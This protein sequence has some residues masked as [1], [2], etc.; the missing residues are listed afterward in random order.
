MS[1]IDPPRGLL[2]RSSECEALERLLAAVRAGGS[3]VLVLRGEAGVGKTALLEHLVARAPDC[4]VAR[5]AGVESE[6]E[7]PFAGLHQLCAPL[8]D[9]LDTLPAPQRDALCTA[10]GLSAGPPPDR[11][12]VG[13]AVLGLLS[14]AAEERPLVCVVDD[15]QWQDRAS[16]LTLAFV[17]RRLAADSV[18]LVFAVREPSEGRDLAGLPEL[19]VHGLADEAAR[20]LLDSVIPGPLDDRVRERIVA[21]TRGN[22]LALLELPRG[23]SPAQLAGGFGVPQVM[24][25]TSRIEQSF[26]ERVESFPPDTRQLL[27]LAAAD[28]IGDVTLLWKAA[29]R[30]GLG[31]AA[32]APA[33]TAGLIELAARVRFRH[34][35]VRSAAYRAAT[36]TDRRQ[37]HRALAEATDSDVDPDRQTWHRA[38]AAAGADESLAGDLERSAGRAQARGGRTATAAFLARAA[39]LTPDPVRRGVRALDAAQ[40]KF[41]AADPDGASELVAT[42]ELCPLDALQRARLHRL[43][44]ELAFIRRR[45][46]DAPPVLLEAAEALAPLDPALSRETYLEAIGAAIFAG[47]HGRGRGVRDVAEAARA[48]PPPPDPPRAIDLLLDGLT[49]R[50]TEGSAAA[51]APLTEALHAYVRKQGQLVADVRWLWLAWPVANEVWDDEEGHQLASRAVTLARDQGMFVGLPIALLYRA[52]VH[53]YAGEFEQAEAL[54]EEADAITEATGSTPLAF[55]ALLVLAYRGRETPALERIEASRRDGDARNDGRTVTLAEYAKAVLL[56]GL[57][58]YPE[59]QAAARRAA[60]HDDL[61]LHGWCLTELVESAARA[62]DREEAVAAAER[63]KARAD[64]GGSD[65]A[66]GLS[67]RSRAL[68]SEGDEA[69]ALYREAIEKLART[70][71]VIHLARAQLVYGEWLRREH[72]R[73]DAR[74]QLRTAH[75]MLAGI[76]AEAFAERARRELLATG[77]TARQRTIGT[78]DE[79]T[80][81]EAQIARLAREGRTNPEIGAQLFISPRTVEWHLR[82][83]FT[84]LDISSR[85]ELRRALPDVTS[86]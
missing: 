8:F 37:A 56:N 44:G 65:W 49:I 14:G 52:G 4:R 68:V 64:T 40:A 70:R 1:E 86:V 13:V 9:R 85:K 66:L 77:E 67:A 24:P 45:G 33:Q 30:L 51:F 43:R 74:E 71:V 72:R 39:E 48:A 36:V 32:A 83:V 57:G 47:R 17:A 3:E 25:L 15:A 53:V 79:L 19:F 34:P 54:I 58:R 81:Q 27:L 75:D 2:G 41:D 73:L 29:G 31:P 50:F 80:A 6:M 38:H 61:G 23:L 82:H 62:G 35:L 22:P 63:L 26:V 76:G 59:A 12:L 46:S 18:G 10:F 28:P 16:L 20:V 5:A 21:E 60:E 69:E 78:R 84:K 55:S 7:L 11:F 42:A